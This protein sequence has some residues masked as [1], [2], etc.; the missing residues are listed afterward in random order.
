MYSFLDVLASPETMLGLSCL[1]RLV[2]KVIINIVVKIVII[3]SPGASR[4]SIFDISNLSWLYLPKFSLYA[5][6]PRWAL[7]TTS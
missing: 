5:L 3:A 7:T 6:I 1:L 2:V 4:M